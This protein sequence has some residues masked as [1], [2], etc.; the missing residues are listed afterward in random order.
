MSTEERYPLT[1][2]IPAITRYDNDQV[3]PDTVETALIRERILIEDEED[4]TMWIRKGDWDGMYPPLCNPTIR[5]RLWMF[6]D[7]FPN[8]TPF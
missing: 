7:P 4:T 2:T 1:Y 5:I 3:L 8:G 6:V